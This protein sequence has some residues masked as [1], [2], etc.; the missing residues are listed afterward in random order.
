M[1]N[2]VCISLPE[3]ASAATDNPD[4]KSNDPTISNS[5][6]FNMA[7]F[8]VKK[9]K[10]FGVGTTWIGHD[11]VGRRSCC[12]VAVSKKPLKKWRLTKL[13]I[14]PVFEFC[15]R[16]SPSLIMKHSKHPGELF[17]RTDPTNVQV[18]FKS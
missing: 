17:F 15:M 14:A 10:F 2:S 5:F 12:R 18:G 3:G 8:L 7:N 6:F 4:I 13:E 16:Y 9:A 1:L 11:A